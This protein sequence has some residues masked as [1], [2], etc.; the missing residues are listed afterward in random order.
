[1]KITE[2]FKAQSD[3]ERR[4]AVTKM[5]IQLESRKHKQTKVANQPKVG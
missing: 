5:M 3:E 2:T 1:M 4:K